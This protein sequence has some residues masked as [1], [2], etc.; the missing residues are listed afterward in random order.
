MLAKVEG[1]KKASDDARRWVGRPHLARAIRAI[2]IGVP[3]VLAVVTGLAT[4]VIFGPPSSVAM[5]VVRVAT[6][7]FVSAV[8]MASAE[9]VFRRLMPLAA[10]YQFTLVFPDHAPSRF[11]VAL[12]SG[13]SRRLERRI[14][15]IR[16]GVRQSG[17][18]QSYYETLLELTAALN[19]HDRLTRGHCERTRAYTEVIIKELELPTADADRLRWASLLHDVGKLGVDAAI[20]NKPGVPTDAEWVQLRAHPEMGAALVEPIAEFLG[21]WISAVSQHHE[22]WDGGGYPGRIAGR[23]IHLGGRIVAVADAYDVMTSARS[24]KRAMSPRDARA[25]LVR[26]SGTQFDPEIVRAFLATSLGRSRASLASLGALI[27]LRDAFALLGQAPAISAVTSTV[28]AAA[29]TTAV[30]TGSGVVDAIPPLPVAPIEQVVDESD[31]GT[32]SPKVEPSFAGAV[33]A[34][35]GPSGRSADAGS[36]KPGTGPSASPPSTV[37]GGRPESPPSTVGGRPHE[38]PPST[39]AGPQKPPPSP[40]TTTLPTTSVPTPVGA[41][42]AP[43]DSSTSPSPPTAGPTPSPPTTERDTSPSPGNPSGKPQGPKGL[44]QTSE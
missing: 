31:V 42:S 1:G 4:G 21:P 6:T 25:E 34:A 14:D 3:I 38:S 18:E 24:Y 37:G 17:P 19:T 8:V 39:V 40:T 13:N 41:M 7:G 28:G 29:L 32:S 36:H 33:P 16:Q 27:H 23:D 30:V 35:S 26:C 9:R 5:A 12:R 11:A 22:R 2:G 43:D 10:M 44:V 20:L 15:E